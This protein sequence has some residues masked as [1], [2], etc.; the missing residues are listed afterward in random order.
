VTAAH[1][2]LHDPRPGI[3]TATARFSRRQSRRPIILSYQV[4]TIQRGPVFMS[5]PRQP[6]C[7]MRNHN[8]DNVMINCWE[9]N[10]TAVLDFHALKLAM[11][12][13][14]V[15][16]NWTLRIRRRGRRRQSSATSLMNNFGTPARLRLSAAS[17]N[18]QRSH[19]RLYDSRPIC[20]S[21]V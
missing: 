8:E 12:G 21:K 19:H 15:A 11:S 9:R 13:G 6:R 7:Q 17:I 3:S 1:P 4:D 10:V 5:A 14:P 20:C 2:R 16:T 18:S